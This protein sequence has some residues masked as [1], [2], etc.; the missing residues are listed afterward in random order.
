[1]DSGAGPVAQRS[2]WSMGL[3]ALCI[4]PPLRLPAGAYGPASLGYA[5]LLSGW[6]YPVLPSRYTH[7]SPYP[8]IP[9]RPHTP[10]HAT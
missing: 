1:M 10:L 7:P 4:S 9:T 2:G 6:V 3:G 8:G 5:P